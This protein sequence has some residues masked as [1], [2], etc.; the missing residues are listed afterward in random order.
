MHPPRRRWARC[1]FRAG[2]TPDA[3][4]QGLMPGGLMLPERL[5]VQHG[6][7]AWW[8]LTLPVREADT[9]PARLAQDR[10]GPWRRW[11]H[12]EAQAVPPWQ[13]PGRR[14]LR[15]ITTRRR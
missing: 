12:A 1:P 9:L 3:L 11:P 7:R 8:R 10:A 5:Y 6:G 2:E 14:R 15:R 4:W 13:T